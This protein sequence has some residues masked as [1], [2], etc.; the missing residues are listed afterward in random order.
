MCSPKVL[1]QCCLSS[2]LILRLLLFP[3]LQE[4]LSPEGKGL[5]ESSFEGLNVPRSLT[6]W[7]ILAVGVYTGSHLLQEETSLVLDKQGTDI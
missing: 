6:L 7:I 1:F 4:T 3:V 2:S 5:M